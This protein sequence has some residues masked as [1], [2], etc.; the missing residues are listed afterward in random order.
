MT[1]VVVVVWWQ[2]YAC[3]SEAGIRLS[4][5]GRPARYERA[6]AWKVA[7]EEEEEVKGV[8]FLYMNWSLV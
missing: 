2:G 1:S 3:L 5:M 6:I 8:A 4:S 7:E